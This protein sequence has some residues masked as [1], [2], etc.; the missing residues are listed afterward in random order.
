MHRKIYTEQTPLEGASLFKGFS[1]Y[2]AN[3][4]TFCIHVLRLTCFLNKYGLNA[5]YV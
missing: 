5:Y 4:I 1:Y 2:N 3:Q